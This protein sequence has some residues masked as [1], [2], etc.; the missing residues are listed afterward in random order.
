MPQIL[1]PPE[2]ELFAFSIP[3]TKFEYKTIRRN[4]KKCFF[5]VYSSRVWNDYILVLRYFL[6]VLN[7]R[8]YGLTTAITSFGLCNDDVFTVL[9]TYSTYSRRVL[10]PLFF[11]KFP[12]NSFLNFTQSNCF[13]L[14]IFVLQYY[15]YINSVSEILK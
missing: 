4:K 2:I 10:A 12:C 8:Y 1:A 11:S 9:F 15:W 7:V 5:H 6:V 14:F 3:K 13:S